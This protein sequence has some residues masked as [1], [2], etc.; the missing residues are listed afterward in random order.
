MEFLILFGALFIGIFLGWELREQYAMR[1]VKRLLE[2]NM[3]QVHEEEETEERTKMRLEKHGVVIYAFEEETD[4]FIAQG[5][6]LFDLDKAI[7][8]R[9]PGKKFSVRE[10][11]L[12]E[13]AKH[14]PV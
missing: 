5:T 8:T 2:E 3:L 13:I 1:T 11:N 12:E 4:T 10:A 9:F 14:D 6:D 7:Q